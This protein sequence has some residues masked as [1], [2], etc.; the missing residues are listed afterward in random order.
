MYANPRAGSEFLDN[1]VSEEAYVAPDPKP[2][3]NLK[4]HSATMA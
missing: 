2:A 1:S 4:Q 3:A